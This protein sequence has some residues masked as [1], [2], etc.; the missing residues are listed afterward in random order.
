MTGLAALVA[1]APGSLVLPAGDRRAAVEVREPL[2]LLDSADLG[3]GRHVAVVED[4]DGGRWTV[5][6]AVDGSD[7]RRARPGDG[8][9]EA[10][11]R[12]LAYAGQHSDSVFGSGRLDVARYGRV[13]KSR[14]L[15]GVRGAGLSY[16]GYWYV[17]K[18]THVI[19]KGSYTQKFSIRREGHFALLPWVKP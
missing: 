7:V 14:E 5:P 6:L 2:R 19:A 9:A 17:T 16:D 8:V 10:L 18:V 12:G 13:L 3:S 1:A 4:A 11:L 15:V